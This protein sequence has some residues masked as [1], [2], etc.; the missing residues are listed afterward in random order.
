VGVERAA[1]EPFDGPDQADPS[2]DRFPVGTND[3][4]LWIVGT[5]PIAADRFRPD[6]QDAAWQAP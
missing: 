4:D 2:G 1:V 5:S 6:R 3:V